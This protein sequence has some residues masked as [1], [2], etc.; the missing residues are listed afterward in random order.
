MQWWGRGAG[1]GNN[2]RKYY[3]IKIFKSKLRANF[4]TRDSVKIWR[5][6]FPNIGNNLRKKGFESFEEICICSEIPR[7]FVCIPKF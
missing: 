5:K 6:I 1:N 3:V 4:E 7:K 2:L